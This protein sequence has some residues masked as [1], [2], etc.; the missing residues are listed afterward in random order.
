MS[1]VLFVILRSTFF[2]IRPKSTVSCITF[3]CIFNSCLVFT[4][5]HTHSIC[6]VQ[7]EVEIGRLYLKKLNQLNLY[8]YLFFFLAYNNKSLTVMKIINMH[9]LNAYYLS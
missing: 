9:L 1:S 6:V 3:D 4:S 5:R 8:L 7:R 2:G